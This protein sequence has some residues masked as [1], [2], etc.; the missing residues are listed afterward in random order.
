MATETSSPV[1]QQKTNGKEDGEWLEITE[2]IISRLKDMVDKAYSD[3]FGQV[4][5]DSP[6]R[7]YQEPASHPTRKRNNMVITKDKAIEMLKQGGLMCET[8]W[9]GYRYAIDGCSVVRGT[10]RK[11]IQLGLVVEEKMGN[12]SPLLKWYKWG[13]K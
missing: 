3:S 2:K 6:S 1:A 12:K 7:G 9:G 5:P 4:K 11:L 8:T 13:E 10:A